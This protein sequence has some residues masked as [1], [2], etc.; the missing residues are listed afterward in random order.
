MRLYMGNIKVVVGVLGLG[1]PSRG[2]S[3]CP[4]GIPTSRAPSKNESDPIM[5]YDVLVSV[6]FSADTLTPRRH[7]QIFRW[8]LSTATEPVI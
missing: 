1:V 2:P 3:Y 6:S 5:L 4:L 7:S 8:S